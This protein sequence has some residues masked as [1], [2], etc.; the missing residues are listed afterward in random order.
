M[1]RN[2]FVCIILAVVT[3]FVG[4]T[5]KTDKPINP[6]SDPAA[7][8]E[9]VYDNE[10]S[11]KPYAEIDEK[12]YNVYYFDA[13]NGADENT[14]TIFQPKRSLAEIGRIVRTATS[15]NPIKILMKRGTRFLGNLTLSGYKSTDEY[16]VVIDAY[17]T[18]DKYPVV[19]ASNGAC[20]KL[21]GGN[22]R[23]RNLELTG[24]NAKQGIYV[25]TS[26]A[27]A[28][29][30]IVVENCYIHDINFHWSR[31]DKPGDV[32]PEV[33]GTEI[34]DITPTADY[35]SRA[36]GGIIFNS[37]TTELVG[38]SW[39]ENIYVLSNRIECVSRTGIYITNR[40]AYK[41]GMSWGNNKYYDDE[42]NWYPHK[43]VIVNDN[44]VDFA[45]GDSIV[46]VACLDS[47]MERNVSYHANFLGREG[48]WNAGI[49]P[50]GCKRTVLQY[51]E[52]AY[53][54]LQ[55]GAGDGEG[56]DIDIACTDIIFQY[57]YSHHNEGGGL[58][59]CNKSTPTVLYNPD[60]SLKLDENGLPQTEMLTP[61]WGNN[62]VRNNV[63][64][65][66]GTT[67][68]KNKS[69]FITVARKCDEL[70]V[71]N[72]ICI[73]RGDIVGQKIIE[74]EDTVNSNGHV[75]SNNIFYCENKNANPTADVLCLFNVRFENNL[76][77]NIPKET[78][79]IFQE[80]KALEFD[81]VFSIS[82]ELNG[83]ESI[84][85]YIPTDKAVFTSGIALLKAAG[86]DALGNDAK[87][88]LYLGAFC[89]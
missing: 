54:Y 77:F 11:A 85:K 16:P 62:H 27:G 78:Q 25:I 58:L 80:K 83:Y 26:K 87:E 84:A 63:F 1:K 60:G 79:E 55:N 37:E 19:E 7:P 86:K 33:L 6:S 76:Y 68:N 22:I 88:K 31:T 29:K 41:P 34:F 48:Y 35:D 38:A 74:R 72:N 14:G 3:F 61:A 8:I 56:F 2:L 75:Y 52:A 32:E 44:F 40:W 50:I 18:V 89:K 5:S 51:N 43:N 59:I 39:F 64:A 42:T 69:A 12:L 45:G 13:V 30:N 65:Y 49:W 53:T 21:E 36:N 82:G 23:I 46:I 9:T 10:T 47:F 24:E 28:S 4:C 17:G 66:N 70:Y 57:N 81:P 67:R 71:Y 15:T 20:I 73:L